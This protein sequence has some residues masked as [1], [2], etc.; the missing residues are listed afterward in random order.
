MLDAFTFS[1]DTFTMS[2]NN[3]IQ[4][5]TQIPYCDENSLFILQQ[6]H[7]SIKRNR[8][9][10][11]FK[12]PKNEGLFD[13]DNLSQS[14]TN[15]S[16]EPCFLPTH[17]IASSIKEATGGIDYSNETLEE[18]W[19]IRQLEASLK[20][21][22]LD[23]K[24]SL[25]NNHCDYKNSVVGTDIDSSLS[26]IKT[27]EKHKIK[28]EENILKQCRLNKNAAIRGLIKRQLISVK[29]LEVPDNSTDV[30]YENNKHVQSTNAYSPSN[31]EENN[32]M[33]LVPHNEDPEVFIQP[34]QAEGGIDASKYKNIDFTVPH[35]GKKK[36][37]TP[38]QFFLSMDD[39]DFDFVKA[40]IKQ[41]K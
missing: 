30:R 15:L 23:K 21:Q 6:E 10:R 2:L 3:D 28:D 27:D 31:L 8:K 14:F 32:C 36:V 29:D 9:M 34:I 19:K 17:E 39:S 41:K 40:D 37:V 1:N 26:E 12:S 7:D 20:S 33:R 38:R 11:K 35:I 16:Q 5:I 4:K 18:Q 22:V 13:N 24:L 25:V